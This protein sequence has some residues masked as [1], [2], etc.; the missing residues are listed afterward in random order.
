M[1][2]GDSDTTVMMGKGKCLACSL[3]L[4]FLFS[5]E[6]PPLCFVSF[7]P[8]WVGRVELSVWKDLEAS[9]ERSWGVFFLS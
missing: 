8:G 9:N 3:V 7:G 5:I 4:F 2:W 6:I 1:G